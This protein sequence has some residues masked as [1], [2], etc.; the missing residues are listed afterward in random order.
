M[1]TWNVIA[2]FSEELVSVSTCTNLRLELLA[3]IVFNNKHG[4][5]LPSL[6][7]SGFCLNSAQLHV[8]SHASIDKRIGN[9]PR[10]AR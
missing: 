5:S 2:A 6:C 3:S 9:V 8:D 1:P 4:Q 7:N 10:D